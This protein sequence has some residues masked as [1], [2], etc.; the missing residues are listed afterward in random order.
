MGL[1]K[2]RLAPLQ[3]VLG[4]AARLIARLPRFSH[5]STFMTEDH[6][7]LR[8]TAR[9]QF[10]ILFLTCEMLHATSVILSDDLSLDVLS[11]L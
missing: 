10:K 4:D 11:A 6:H 5:I 8:L 3:S 9:I 1:P 2:L 7:W